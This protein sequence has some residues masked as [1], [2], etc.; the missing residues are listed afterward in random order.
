MNALLRNWLIIGGIS[1]LTSCSKENICD[2]FP[3]SVNNKFVNKFMDINYRRGM[4]VNNTNINER[5]TSQDT[6]Y[7][8]ADSIWSVWNRFRYIK[9]FYQINSTLSNL[10]QIN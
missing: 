7:F 10:I 3:C 5:S 9:P 6:T 1:F 8:H 4:W 2:T